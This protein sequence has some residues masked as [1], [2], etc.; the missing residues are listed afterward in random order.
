MISLCPDQ[1]STVRE[2]VAE[3]QEAT[4]LA[5]LAGRTR[6]GEMDATP[7]VQAAATAVERVLKGMFE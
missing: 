2:A 5:H 1:M 3:Q 6:R 4:G 7:M